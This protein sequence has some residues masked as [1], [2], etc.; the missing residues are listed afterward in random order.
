MIMTCFNF[1]LGKR[2]KSSSSAE[3]HI[4]PGISMEWTNLKPSSCICS[5]RV[6]LEWKIHWQVH[7]LNL[8]SL[9]CIYGPLPENALANVA[10]FH[11]P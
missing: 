11:V 5:N 7:E 9:T 2:C 8:P 3:L 1:E 10:H 4:D 6:V